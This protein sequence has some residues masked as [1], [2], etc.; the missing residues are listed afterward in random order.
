MREEPQVA[1]FNARN[2]SHPNS[3]L[4]CN[5][6]VTI[7]V[8]AAEDMPIPELFHGAVAPEFTLLNA[9]IACYF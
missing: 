7:F 5:F 3:L 8:F 4:P 6:I 9:P 2:L 1:S